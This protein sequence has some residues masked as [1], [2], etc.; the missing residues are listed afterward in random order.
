MLA[1][2]GLLAF[3]EDMV[4]FRPSIAV[5]PWHEN[6]SQAKRDYFLLTGLAMVIKHL[7]VTVVEPGGRSTGRV[8]YIKVRQVMTLAINSPCIGMADAFHTYA[9]VV[10]WGIHAVPPIGFNTA[11]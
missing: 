5:F 9:W 7:I 4:R 8:G 2:L 6:V 11:G 3:E 1:Y 10:Q